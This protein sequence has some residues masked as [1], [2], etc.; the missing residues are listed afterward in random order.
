MKRVMIVDDEILV[1]IGIKSI[2]QWEKYGYKMVAEATN[3]DEALTLIETTKPDIILTDLMMSP[4]DGFELIE[5]CK[6][7]YPNIKFIVLS[8]YNDMDNVKKA[9]KL[10]AADYIFKLKV[11]PDNIIKVLDEV[12]KEIIPEKEDKMLKKNINFMKQKLMI[13]IINK[14]YSSLNEVLSDMKKMHLKV[15]LENTYVTLLISIDD[16]E[17]NTLNGVIENSGIFKF[18]I[19]NMI[20]EI[21]SKYLVCDVYGC[22]QGDVIITILLD[23]SY[24]DFEKKII[25]AFEKINEYTK[26]YLDCTVSGGISYQCFSIKDI[27]KAFFQVKNGIKNRLLKGQAFLYFESKQKEVKKFSNVYEDGLFYKIENLIEKDG[28]KLNKFIEDFFKSV[29]QLEN[30]SETEARKY[31][32]DLYTEIKNNVKKYDIALEK[33][34][35]EYGNSLY[36]IILKSDTKNKIKEGFDFGVNKIVL[37]MNGENIQIPRSDIQNL[38]N[39][40]CNHLADELTGSFAAEM[41]GMNV[42]YFSHIFKKETGQSFVDYVN[43]AR[44]KKA[45]ELLKSTDYRIYEIAKMVGIE[46]PNYFS[47][48]FKKI[49]GKNPN[50]LRMKK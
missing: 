17:L 16:Y 2:V 31:Y 14:S 25:E 10:G 12:S 26:R 13:T 40:I 20:D 50:D 44:I 5:K 29:Q 42:S 19:I 9:I 21:L 32:L 33:I 3:G 22:S 34:K 7:I 43:Y 18:T 23:S 27:R 15:D 37:Q 36:D 6:I 48:L 35:D 24:E 41:L 30:V 47:I 39:Y 28:V 49:T 11:T 4:M 8:S 46:S 45:Q 38:K 1:R